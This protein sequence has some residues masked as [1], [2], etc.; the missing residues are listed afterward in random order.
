MRPDL[1]GQACHSTD[2][3]RSWQTCFY[4][5]LSGLDLEAC[6]KKDDQ[7]G[8]TNFGAQWSERAL[9]RNGPRGR[10]GPPWKEADSK[11]VYR[12]PGNGQTL[13]DACECHRCSGAGGRTRTDMS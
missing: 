9:S 11:V 7:T 10:P 2:F 13:D 4:T 3:D 12:N 8:L 1:R 6:T 5:R